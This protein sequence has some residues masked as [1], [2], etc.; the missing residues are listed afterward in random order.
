MR[1]LIGK[2]VCAG[3]LAGLAGMASGA[4]VNILALPAS[5]NIT[6]AAGETLRV[7]YLRGGTTLYKSGAGRLEVAVVENPNLNVVVSNGTFA[8]T[9]PGTL[10][11][12]GDDSVIFHLNAT[13]LATVSTRT[14]NG[15]NFVTAV[16]DAAGRTGRSLATLSGRPDVML[17]A[18]GING[19]PA[20]DFGSLHNKA[21]TGYGAALAFDVAVEGAYEML[22]VFED[23]PNAKYRSKSVGPCPYGSS[24]SIYIRGYV[25]NGVSAPIHCADVNLGGRAQEGNYIDGVNYGQTGTDELDY[26]HK[27]VPDGPHVMRNRINQITEGYQFDPVYGLGYSSSSSYSY[28]GLK[29][30]EVVFFNTTDPKIYNIRPVVALMQKYLMLKWQD[31]ATVGMVTLLNDAKLDVAAAPLRCQMQWTSG[32]ATVTGGLNLLPKGYYEA[33][34]P[35]FAVGGGAV[36]RAGA[37]DGRARIVLRRRCRPFRF[38]DRDAGACRRGGYARQEGKRNADRWRPWHAGDGGC[39]SGRRAPPCAA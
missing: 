28:G 3:C 13:S 34:N 27:P 6:V 20:L 16:T 30:G 29:I 21:A 19:L 5:T 37:P 12:S 33:G 2:S 9:M 32:A 17:A 31:V 11:L 8:T 10:D 14:E 15:T 7:E 36:R 39:G 23:D 18:D 4:D 38:G 25:E 26:K 1:S 35:V 24:A 22:C